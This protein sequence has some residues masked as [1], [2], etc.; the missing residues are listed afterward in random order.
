MINA[1]EGNG[2]MLSNQIS[3][4]TPLSGTT[5]A[6]QNVF[7]MYGS[8]GV[9]VP[10]KNSAIGSE[11][12]LTYASPISRK[13]S[14]DSSMLLSSFSNVSQNQ[15]RCSGDSYSFL[16]EDISHQIQLQQLEIDRFISQHVRFLLF[17]PLSILSIR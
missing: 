2:N 12:G 14:R 3:Y 7:P 13:R 1:I 9:A 15:N 4:V 10:A 17:Y 16:G 8:G 11:S 5:T 6:T